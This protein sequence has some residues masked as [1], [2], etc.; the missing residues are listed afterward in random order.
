[1]V[2]VWCFIVLI[3]VLLICGL[4]PLI[5]PLYPFKSRTCFLII[6][7]AKGLGKE[8]ALQISKLGLNLTFILADILP[9]DEL[10]ILS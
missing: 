3:Y 8:I 1:M 7:A 6:G 2:V 10:S 9:C 5:R 4:L